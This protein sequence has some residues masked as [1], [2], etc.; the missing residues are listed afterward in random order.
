MRKKENPGQRIGR[1]DP[2]SDSHSVSP[3]VNKKSDERI[4][5]SERGYSE[6]TAGQFIER[7]TSPAGG[8]IPEQ[9]SGN[10]Q[11]VSGGVSAGNGRLNDQRQECMTEKACK[12]SEG[13]NKEREVAHCLRR[14]KAESLTNPSMVRIMRS[15]R[16][17]LREKMLL[18]E[19]ESDDDNDL[20]LCCAWDTLQCSDCT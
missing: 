2:I 17:Y 10:I 20:L 19:S 9:F 15:R 3:C 14:E 7:K 13:K 5:H 8:K 4:T 18:P 11:G 16:I 12:K 1:S 6:T